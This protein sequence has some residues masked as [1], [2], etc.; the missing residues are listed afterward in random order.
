MAHQP[1]V[2][3]LL[4]YRIVTPMFRHVLRQHSDQLIEGLA[5]AVQVPQLNLR[6]RC[7]L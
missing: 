1:E 5:G 4:A 2:F 3:Q 6:D 7:T